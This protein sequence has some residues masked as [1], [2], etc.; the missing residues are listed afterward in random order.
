MI[1]KYIKEITKMIP[2]AFLAKGDTIY[3]YGKLNKE[4]DY[5]VDPTILLPLVEAIK[6][7]IV[8]SVC[9][10]SAEGL[11][12]TLIECS[13]P[14]LLGFDI[15]GDSDVEDDEFLN[16]KS[17]Y[18]A[19]VSLNEDQENEFVDKMFDLGIP[20]TLLGHVTKGNLRMDDTS[21]GF[22]GDYI[23]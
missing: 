20:L 21:F 3:L 14:N 4:N 19:I 9:F 22:I 1:E 23:N 16:G 8:E 11:F 6:G 7:E 15:T 18:V 5:Q 2:S 12:R 13:T 10:I 17:Q